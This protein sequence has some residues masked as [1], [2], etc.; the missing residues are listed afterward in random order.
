MKARKVSGLPV[1]E[2]GG[3]GKPGKLVGFL[4]SRD[5]RFATDPNQPVHELMTKDRLITVREHVDLTE[6]KQLIHQYRIEKLLVV[7]EQYRCVGLVALKDIERAETLQ[8]THTSMTSSRSRDP[9][10]PGWQVGQLRGIMVVNPLTI[11]PNARLSDALTLMKARK[12]SG[13]PVVENGGDGKPGK[14]VGFLTSR[15]IRFAT[16]PNRPVHELMTKDRLITVREHVDLTEAK[17]LIHQHRIEKLLVVDEQYRCVGLVTLKDIERAE[18]LQATLELGSR[19]A[20]KPDLSEQPPGGHWDFFLSYSS[21]DAPFAH[22]ILELLSA[23]GLRIFAQSTNMPAGSNFVREMQKGLGGSGRVIALL[24]PAYIKSDHCQAEW[25]AAYN[26]D[27]SGEARKL[28]S[29]LI[30]PTELP[31]L[32]KQIVYQSLIGLSRSDAAK[33]VLKALAYR[34]PLP[35]IPSDWPGGAAMDQLQGPSGRIFDVAPR[36]DLRL[37]RKPNI[38]SDSSEAFTHQELFAISTST[39]ADFFKYVHRHID[40]FR[41]SDRLKERATRLHQDVCVG[42]LRCDPLALNRDLVWVLRIIALDKADGLIPRNDEFDYHA[43]DLYGVYNRLEHIFP[44]LKLYR[45]MDA[46]HRFEPPSAEVENAITSIYNSFGNPE[47]SEGALSAS[48]SRE[49]TQAGQGIE[50]AKALAEKETADKTLELTIESH[51][52][53]ATRSLA[54]WSWLSNASEKLARTGKTAEE[55]AQ[56]IERYEKLYTALAPQ[57]ARYLEYL[58]KWFF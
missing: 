20:T 13:L 46:R 49:M 3:D 11:S 33:A 38:I 25:S 1:V 5:I 2:N 8:A 57:M 6:A 31:P 56:A 19:D 17:R 22:W 42:F 36:A 53:A 52:D 54:V 27:P 26:S 32:A 23:A 37:E 30:K 9:N 4:A 15:D 12:V 34:G 7:D 40:N 45:K 47:I 41:C 39:V 35:A 43:S 55:I 48:L 21:D 29:F 10:L 28:I 58:L 14:L 50:D 16:D 24:S 44:N 18:S 51:A